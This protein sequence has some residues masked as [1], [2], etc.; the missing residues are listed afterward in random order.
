M[1][2]GTYVG[3]LDHDDVLEPDALAEVFAALRSNPDIDYLYTD[4]DLLGED[5]R[6]REAFRKPDWSPERFRNQMYVCHFSVIRQTLLREIG[7]FR[8]GFDGSQ[9]Y[10][11]MLRVTERA[12]VIH[13]VPKVLYHWRIIEGSVAGDPN[14]KP[15]A[16][17]AGGNAL[18]DHC[19]RIGI[20][21]SVSA[22]PDLPGNYLIKRNLPED[23]PTVDF[24][25]PYVGQ[26]TQVWGRQRKH[27]VE[28]IDSLKLESS[29]PNL[30]LTK[31]EFS[32]SRVPADLNDSI[33]RSEHDLVIIGSGM[34]QVGSTDWCERL[35]GFAL[36]DDV[37]MVAPYVWT[38][39]SRLLHAAYNLRPHC[40][41][42]AGKGI[43]KDFTGFRA[44]FHSD[45][46]VSAVGT[47]CTLVKKSIFL[48]AGGFDPTLSSPYAE[49]DLC[50]RIGRMGY[51]IISTPQAHMWCFEENNDFL[52]AKYRMSPEISRRWPEESSWDRYAGLPK[53]IGGRDVRR[54][55]W[56]PRRLRHFR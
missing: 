56:Q 6:T 25:V 2:R 36:D 15:Y 5:G 46:E 11:L 51:R 31:L 33:I 1:A 45:R 54:P 3:L 48:E 24:I 53:E 27:D 44:V 14:A 26:S 13:H 9:D 47:F 34:L 17:T 37:A 49:I 39:N 29:Y 16:Y 50:L 7:G 32:R 18:K 38:A 28:T 20:A 41:E 40:I 10:D 35:V 30:V 55:L 23:L 12:R 43:G 22:V 42:N 52:G 4:E 8:P 21:A 19:E